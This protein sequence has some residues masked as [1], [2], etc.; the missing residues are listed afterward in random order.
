MSKLVLN[1][2]KNKFT[3]SAVCFYAA[4]AASVAAPPGPAVDVINPGR[5]LLEQTAQPTPAPAQRPAPTPA[6]PRAASNPNEPKFPIRRIE[7]S[8]VTRL[9]PQRVRAITGPYENRSLGASDINVLLE[10]LTRAYVAK[11]YLTTRVYLPEQNLRTGVLKLQVLEGRLASFSTGP[12]IKQGQL[13]PQLPC[14]NRRSAREYSD[15][16]R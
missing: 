2:L 7:V 1:L 10:A 14:L 4:V 11:G 3:L 5:Q 16:S 13:F 12:T 9:S 8:G 6:P 15:Q